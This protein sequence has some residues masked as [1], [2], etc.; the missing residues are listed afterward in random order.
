MRLC[1]QVIILAV[2]ALY[3]VAK[4]P[5]LVAVLNDSPKDDHTFL[6]DCPQLFLSQ[7]VQKIDLSPIH[8]PWVPLDLSD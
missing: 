5:P 3:V 4:F 6:V 2:V 8:E 1:G 7:M